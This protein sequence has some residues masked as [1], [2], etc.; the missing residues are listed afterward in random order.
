VPYFLSL[1]DVGLFFIK[2]VFSKTAS[3]PTKQGEIMGMGIPIICNDRVGDTGPI[4]KETGAGIVL[5]AFDLSAYQMAVDQ[6]SEV[7]K[8][9]RAKIRAGAMKYYSLKEGVARYLEV[10]QDLLA[11]ES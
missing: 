1:A 11:C 2:P 6:L 10:Y 8:I 9:P 7:V 3:S 4:I 5:S